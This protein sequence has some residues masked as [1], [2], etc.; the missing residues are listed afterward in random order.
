MGA[1]K[2]VSFLLSSF[3]LAYLTPWAQYGGGPG[4]TFDLPIHYFAPKS[5][6]LKLEW[7]FKADY[8]VSS[9][10]LEN[11]VL[12]ADN[13]LFVFAY[14]NRQRSVVCIDSETGEFL[15]KR[16]CLKI[17]QV[18]EELYYADGKIFYV[19]NE[20]KLEILDADSGELI[21]EEFLPSKVFG[22]SSMTAADGKL[23][24]STYDGISCYSISERKFIWS[25][26]D[27]RN[28]RTIASVSNRVCVYMTLYKVIAL[29]TKDG[30]LLWD[31]NLDVD[32]EKEVDKGPPILPWYVTIQG[33]KA[34]Y[35][36]SG[37]VLRCVKL[38]NGALLDPKIEGIEN[39]EYCITSDG[40]IYVTTITGSRT[41]CYSPDGKVLWFKEK[42]S[43]NGKLVVCGDRLYCCDINGTISKINRFTGEEVYRM[44][45]P[46]PADKLRIGF[47]KFFVFSGYFIFCYGD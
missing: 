9:R 4:H 3:I 24:I 20:Q 43:F 25:Y 28:C 2:L 41:T 27:G 18:G 14:K 22:Y 44:N 19:I 36:D 26:Y 37:P 42:P 15:W 33:D 29:R 40:Y 16:D 35:I 13:K 23:Y 8:G 30:S 34:Y 45:P 12:V 32:E 47:G 46:K 38:D 5:N 7:Q 6:E 11:D 39:V 21:Q 17:D 10:Y 1:V 31:R